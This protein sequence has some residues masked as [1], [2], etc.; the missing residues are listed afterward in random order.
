MTT[1]VDQKYNNT[2]L[3]YLDS[4]T[5]IAITTTSSHLYSGGTI[6]KYGDLL[7]QYTVSLGDST[8]DPT[9]TISLQNGWG[10]TV[11]QSTAIVDSTTV[12]R[13]L[14]TSEQVILQGAYSIVWTLSTNSPTTGIYDY[15]TFGFERGVNKHL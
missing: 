1:G 8:G 15:F 6:T 9:R 13:L 11:W 2:D 3:Y 10:E 12:T 5:Q 4:R 7:R 14:P